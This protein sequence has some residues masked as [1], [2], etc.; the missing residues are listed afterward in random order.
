[1]GTKYLRR[2]ETGDVKCI[3]LADLK[4]CSMK[5]FLQY[6]AKKFQFVF[7]MYIY[8]LYIYVDV[9]CQNKLKS[10]E[11]DVKVYFYNLIFFSILKVKNFFEIMK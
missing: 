5:K 11:T 7:C 8:T 6:I 9:E 1:M 10:Y 2:K 3:Q 4:I